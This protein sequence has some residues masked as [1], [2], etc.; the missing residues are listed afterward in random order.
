MQ[1][2]S[3]SLFSSLF[4]APTSLH[5]V[6]LSLP[7]TDFFILN[8]DDA[9]FFPLSFQLRPQV[10]NAVYP[11]MHQMGTLFVGLSILLIYSDQPEKLVEVQ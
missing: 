4:P 9:F 8:V 10:T 3:L 2:L 5:F 6:F 11:T 7:R 1:K